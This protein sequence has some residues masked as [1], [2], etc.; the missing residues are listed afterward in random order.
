MSDARILEARRHAFTKKGEGRGRGSHLDQDGIDAARGL[1]AELGPFARVYT[2]TVPR[3]L[4]TAVAM[5]F[6]VD[7][8]LPVLGEVSD[9]VIAEI[10]HHERW[11]WDAPFVEFHHHVD[12]GGATGRMA[13]ALR[14]TWTRILEGLPEG[15]RRARRSCAASPA[16]ANAPSTTAELRTA[17]SQASSGIQLPWNPC[18]TRRGRCTRATGSFSKSTASRI[19]RSLVS[20]AASYT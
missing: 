8:Q 4:E 11:S 7:E 14:D 13:G 10:G 18:G 12:A 15:A 6:A 2:S 19:T 9:D 5:G 1:G 17:A 16:G 3:A 20:R